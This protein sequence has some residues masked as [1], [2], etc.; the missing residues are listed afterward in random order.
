MDPPPEA[1]T[2]FEQG[3]HWRIEAYFPAAIDGAV[4]ARTIEALW[5]DGGPIASFAVAPVPNVNWVAISQAALPP[6]ATGRFVV[7]GSHDRHRVPQGPNA[8]LID[9]GEAFGTA[10]HQTTAGCLV[11][12]DRLT[13]QSAYRGGAFR[14]VLD[15]GCGS[16]VL[17]IAVS[18]CLPQ[19][20]IL[21]SDMDGP[22]VAVAQMN[23][24]LNGA[25]GRVRCVLA[26][27]LSHP[28]L[29]A[30]APFDLLIANILAKPLIG[31]APDLAAAVVPGGVL[32]LSGLLIPQARQI[33]QVYN[34]HGFRLE[35]HDRVD[36][37]STLTM[38]R[39]G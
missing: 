7:H 24:R 38:M 16:G 15:L 27:G 35:R 22:S 23:T 1:L 39:K 32:L 6:V 19:A 14:N 2:L 31:L 17:A 34:A 37:W 21:A 29:R 30:A 5:P 28:E 13:R 36:G 26:A 8:I 20:S 10:H 4:L 11:A 33:I 25:G 3:E 12:I 18:R 9:A